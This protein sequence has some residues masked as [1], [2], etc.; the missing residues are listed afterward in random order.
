MPGIMGVFAWAAVWCHLVPLVIANSLE[1]SV[2]AQYFYRTG[3]IMGAISMG[4]VPVLIVSIVV[5]LVRKGV[6]LNRE[7]RIKNQ[8]SKI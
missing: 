6:M 4:W 3:N 8:E 1:N 2:A 7:R 5:W